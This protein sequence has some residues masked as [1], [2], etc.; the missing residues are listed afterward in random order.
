MTRFVTDLR[1]QYGIFGGKSQTS[2]SRNA[3][4]AGSE[5]GELFKQAKLSSAD[6]KFLTSVCVLSILTPKTDKTFMS[7]A[8]C[9]LLLVSVRVIFSEDCSIP[10][11]TSLEQF[12]QTFLN[13][14]R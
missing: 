3:T 9:M 13:L 11:L 10:T 2:F 1:H 6:Y 7:D 8:L 4:R 14:L 12:S 5:E